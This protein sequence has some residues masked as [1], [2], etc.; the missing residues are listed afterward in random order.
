[1]IEFEA[2]ARLGTL[3]NSEKHF[4]EIY[5]VTARQPRWT[6]QS[7]RPAG[8]SAGLEPQWHNDLSDMI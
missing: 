5:R 3:L 7:E 6:V 4:P 1:M 2:L 8:M